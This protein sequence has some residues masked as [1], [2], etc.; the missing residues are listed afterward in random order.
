MNNIKVSGSDSTSSQATA[1]Q[2]RCNIHL[3]MSLLFQCN[4]KNVMYTVAF[5]CEM[6]LHIDNFIRAQLP[7]SQL[8]VNV[9]LP[10]D[11]IH[12]FLFYDATNISAVI[13]II[14]NNY[15]GGIDNTDCNIKS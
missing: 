6:Y 1:F 8:V 7:R 5:Y 13:I 9:P 11:F 10:R 12:F 14:D 15:C 2:S 3:L 4:W